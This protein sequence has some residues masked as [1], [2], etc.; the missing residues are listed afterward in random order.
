MQNICLTFQVPCVKFSLPE[1]WHKD[2]CETR[3]RSPGRVLGGLWCKMDQKKSDKSLRIQVIVGA[4]WLLFSKLPPSIYIID[5]RKISSSRRF[6]IVHFFPIPILGSANPRSFASYTDQFFSY[7]NSPIFSFVIR[8][9]TKGSPVKKCRRF[10]FSCSKKRNSHEAVFPEVSAIWH[11]NLLM[12]LC[13]SGAV[14]LS[15]N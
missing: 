8:E 15:K 3:Q 4:I 7:E 5:F 13:L 14:R 2:T 12:I 1:I 11:K 10:S 6:S 9:S